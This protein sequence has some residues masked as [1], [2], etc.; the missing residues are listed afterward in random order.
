MKHTELEG[1]FQK[2]AGSIGGNVPWRDSVRGE[3]L[4]IVDTNPVNE[5]HDENGV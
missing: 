2:D 4:V 1:L 3:F 5:F